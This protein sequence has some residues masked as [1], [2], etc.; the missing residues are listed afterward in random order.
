MQDESRDFFFFFF[1]FCQS[2]ERA[3]AGGDLHSRSRMS[4]LS[5]C[6]FSAADSYLLI[7]V[8]LVERSPVS[9][10]DLGPKLHQSSSG[11]ERYFEFPQIGGMTD[12]LPFGYLRF[13]ALMG[14]CEKHGAVAFYTAPM[15][16]YLY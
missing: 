11:A 9:N 13:Q 1:I 7:S 2:K 15:W 4:L 8:R 10:S 5:L 12:L 16:N 3:G 6:N 14:N